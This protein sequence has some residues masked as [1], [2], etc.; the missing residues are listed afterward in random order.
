LLSGDDPTGCEFMLLGGHGVISVTANVVPEK[1][2]A[3]V[4][5]ATAGDAAT[6]KAIDAEMASIHEAMFVQSNPIPVKWALAQMGKLEANYRLPMTEPELPQ[7]QHI[8]QTLK[9]AG[10]I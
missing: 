10:L 4:V 8:E 5:A 9:Q 7:Q 2:K 6:A 3:M 1:M